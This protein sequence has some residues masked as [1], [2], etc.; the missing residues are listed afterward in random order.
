M[1]GLERGL[2]APIAGILSDRWGPKRVV[3]GGLI[4]C[5]LGFILLSRVT[6]LTMFFTSFIIIGI[7]V[8]ATATP[9]LM[10]LVLSWFPKKGGL[11]MGIAASGVALGGLLVPLITFFIDTFGW[12]QAIFILGLGML[13]VPLPLSLLLRKKT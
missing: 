7:G 1:R 3:F 11:A 10:V 8:S 12:R 13:A 6:S 9:L 4:L 5:S 2:L